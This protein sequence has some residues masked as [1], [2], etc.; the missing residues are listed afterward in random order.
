M[1]LHLPTVLIENTPSVPIWYKLSVEVLGEKWI[2]CKI[3]SI[4]HFG[5]QERIMFHGVIIVLTDYY[6]CYVND[7]LDNMF[8]V[9]FKR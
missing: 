8:T 7:V 4:L 2:T 9:Q 5:Y 6:L 3:S 1:Y